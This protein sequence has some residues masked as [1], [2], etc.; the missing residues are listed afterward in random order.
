MNF[1]IL[2]YTQKMI[3]IHREFLPCRLNCF[4]QARLN[5]KKFLVPSF[6]D[7]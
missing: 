7:N 2:K 6:S 1:N 3:K 5:V 4:R